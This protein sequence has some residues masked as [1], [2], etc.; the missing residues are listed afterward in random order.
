VP[1][2][3]R[4]IAGAIC[5]SKAGYS[6]GRSALDALLRELALSGPQGEAVEYRPEE[7]PS[8]IPGRCA[9][10]FTESGERIA[11]LFELHPQVLENFG[12][13][14]PVVLFSLDLGAVTYH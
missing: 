1:I 4:V 2:E 5:S 8:G 9:A 13:P 12:L 14:N 6:E 11:E 10:V 3:H 7:N